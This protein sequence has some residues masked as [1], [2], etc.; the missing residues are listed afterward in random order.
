[1]FVER[2]MLCNLKAVGTKHTALAKE[3][4]YIPQ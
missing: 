4:V 2:V 1:M 3:W